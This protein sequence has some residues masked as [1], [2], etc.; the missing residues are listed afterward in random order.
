MFNTKITNSYFLAQSDD[1]IKLEHNAKELHKQY[2]IAKR[3]KPTHALKM[4]EVPNRT[5][6]ELRVR[7]QKWQM[8]VYND[9]KQR[10]LGM[11]LLKLM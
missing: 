3:F 6:W 11:S 5:D 4:L 1:S 7:I 8:K 10:V 9:Q 2:I